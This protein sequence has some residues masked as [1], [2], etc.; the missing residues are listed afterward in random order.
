MT[1]PKLNE[2]HMRSELS[3]SAFFRQPGSGSEPLRPPAEPQGRPLSV[4]SSELND[5]PADQPWARSHDR[6]G[7]RMPARRH[8]RRA[9]FEVYQDQLDDLR[10]FSL[11]EKMRGELGSMSEM[12]R[13]G[14]DAYI[15]QRLRRANESP[16][17]PE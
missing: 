3:D 17:D 6:S 2:T 12:V 8:I 4:S 10:R 11:D 9:S 1:K 15:E 5:R 13:E 16:D 14:L 7:D